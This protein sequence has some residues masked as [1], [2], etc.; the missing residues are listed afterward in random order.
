M[1]SDAE[2]RTIEKKNSVFGAVSVLFEIKVGDRDLFF[3][4]QLDGTLLFLR[5]LIN[6]TQA[7]SL[8]LA[9]DVEMMG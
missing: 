6:G 1:V 9:S 4:D 7:V 2:S 3:S 8:N 5:R